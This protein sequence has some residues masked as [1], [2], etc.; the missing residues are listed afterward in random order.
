MKKVSC[1]ITLLIDG[2]EQKESEIIDLIKSPE[3]TKCSI[4][5]GA[6]VICNKEYKCSFIQR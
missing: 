3:M 1:T 2:K 5:Y 4:D 6:D